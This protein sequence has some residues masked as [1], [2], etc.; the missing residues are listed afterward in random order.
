M[1]AKVY[2]AGKVDPHAIRGLFPANID[3]KPAVVEYEPDPELRDTEQI[4]LLEDG[5]IE[6]Y[7]PR[8]ASLYAR[9]VDR[10]K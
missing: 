8:S 7:P 2:R 6:N 4:P 5:C 3:G 10:Q 1:V 9:R